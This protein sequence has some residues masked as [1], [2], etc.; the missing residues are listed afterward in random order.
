MKG[1]NALTAS[2]IRM[3]DSDSATDELES[4]DMPESRAPRS[5]SSI[6]TGDTLG[7]TRIPKM[8]ETELNQCASQGMWFSPWPP[9]FLK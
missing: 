4:R 2:A 1:S 9:I 5:L 6:V 3:R 7:A 8:R